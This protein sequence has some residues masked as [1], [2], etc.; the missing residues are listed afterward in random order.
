MLKTMHIRNVGLIENT[1]LP[2]E[3]GLSILTGQTGA[4][5][6]MLIG[7]LGLVLGRRAEQNL[8][9][10][11]DDKAIVEATFELPQTHPLRP[12]LAEL[13]IPLENGNE[14]IVR[15]VVDNSG[16]S[17]AYAGGLR[18]TLTQ[19]QELAAELVDIHSQFDNHQLLKPAQ[20]A[21]LLDDFGSLYTETT[22]VEAS[23]NTWHTA[24]QQLKKLQHQQTEKAYE[25][26]LLQSYI[27]ELETLAPQENEEEALSTERKQL[28]SAEQF[29]QAL[30]QADD[31][32]NGGQAD[33]TSRIGSA[34]RALE[35]LPTADNTLQELAERLNT[36]YEETRELARQ[37]GSLS[38]NYQPNPERLSAV[39]ERLFT[40]KTCARKHGCTLNELPQ[41]LEKLQTRLADLDDI[42]S[43][44]A[45]LEKETASHRTTFEHA[46][47]QLST[48]RQHAAAKLKKSIESTAHN[49]MMPGTVFEA[50][51]TPL[52]PEHWSARGAEKVGFLV[53]T[54]AGK[55]PQP[56][57]KVA[58]GG[59]IS[60]LMLALKQ[61]LYAGTHPMLL[62]FDEVDTGVGGA[63]ADAIGRTLQ[64]MAG[65]HQ[66]LAITHLPQV[67]ACGS[68]HF[69]MEKHSS[70]G[71]TRSTVRALNAH[72]RTE[73]LARMLAGA[74]VT[75]A[76]R[77]AAS[78]LLHQKSA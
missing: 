14:L 62:I 45:K 72:E 29:V 6:S 32:L 47:T 21:S 17:T 11:F 44:L 20:H 77:D 57:E 76:A 71:T 3:G 31:A 61:V 24:R 8:L 12:V 33:V 39:D 7:A 34:A 64:H 78:S 28:M 74:E 16:K 10:S 60:R 53:S 52:P 40:L 19:M 22:A 25:T 70:T 49:L 15:R 42:D 26:E 9:G 18:I 43:A 41:T 2:L 13:D 69:Y 37:L 23:F 35:T 54:N 75:A 36:L 30:Q 27:E 59:E 67:A 38:D 58:S 1:T 46:C 68:A 56:L 66:V 5:K 65:V 51:L 55:T 63:V 50:A 48:A 73:E 4:G